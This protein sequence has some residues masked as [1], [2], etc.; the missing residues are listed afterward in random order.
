M[1]TLAAQQTINFL[2][3]YSPESLY[4]SLKTNLCILEDGFP[5]GVGLET[6]VPKTQDKEDTVF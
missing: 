1:K 3:P 5:S 2:G 6:E 4:V